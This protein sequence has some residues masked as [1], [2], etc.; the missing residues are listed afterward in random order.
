MK[1]LSFSILAIAAVALCMFSCGSEPKEQIPESFPRKQL[2]EHFTSQSCGYCP[3]GINFIEEVTKSSSNIV[4]V[5]NHAGFADDIFTVRGS[6]TI[7]STFKI[8]SAPTIMLNRETVKTDEGNQRAFHPYYLSKVIGSQSVTAPASVVIDNTYDASTRDVK[9]KISGQC[10]DKNITQY[11]LTVLIKESGMVAAQ[12]DYNYTFEGWE[13]FVHTNAVRAFLSD[14]VGDVVSLKNQTYSAEYVYTLSDKWVAEN[15]MVV[16]YLTEESNTPVVNAEECPVVSGTKGGT[17]IDGGGVTMVAVP[18]D[19]PEEGTAI[20]RVEYSQAQYSLTGKVGNTNLFY[21]MLVGPD[22]LFENDSY[23]P[24]A[25]L[26]I[27]ADADTLPYGTYELVA[28]EKLTAGSALQGYKYQ[29]PTEAYL[30]GS[31]LYYIDAAYYKTYKNMVYNQLYLLNKGSIEIS[32]SGISYQ[33]TTLNGSNTSGVFEGKAKLQRVAK[34][35]NKHQ[36]N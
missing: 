9:V 21:I 30:D 20:E 25:E 1:K 13:E 8:N 17:D 26:Y 29:T 19:Y 24:A 33:A 7:A 12:S 22:Y 23:F 6:K 35:L 11:K 2:L 16:A 10:A 34:R 18:E 14:P 4:W 28:P 3:Y 36:L 27:A 31:S 15:C 5:S 32:E